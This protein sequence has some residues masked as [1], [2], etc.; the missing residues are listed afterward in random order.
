MRRLLVA[1]FIVMAA[2]VAHAA[3]PADVPILR[4]SYYEAP[5]AAYRTNW[6]G[7]YAGGHF[8]YSSHD[9]DFSRTTVGLQEY[10]LRESALAAIVGQWQLL[11]TSNTR[12]S[13]FGGFVG[14]NAQYEDAIIGIE[15]NYT[16]FAAKWGDS[17]AAITRTLSA[18]DG[19][20]PPPGHSY[21]FDV[22][23]A[24]NARAKVNDMVT[25]RA[26]GG[27]A[28]G[29]FM[30]YVFGG[31]AVALVD[32]D[33]AA[34]VR[35]RTRDL[36]DETVIIG[37]DAG[38][39]PITTIVPRNIVISD[40]TDAKTE[41]QKNLL[42]FGFTAGLGFEYM[43]MQNIFLRAEYEYAQ[44]PLAKDTVIQLNTG[45]IGLGAKF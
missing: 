41:S 9:F 42:T 1:G 2:Q 26:R 19:I 36:F 8:G 12:A 13:G 10:M 22:T 44:L 31:L 14:Y 29:N 15:A 25:L 45:R 38:G 6:G 21:E 28:M 32:I 34:T 27:Y 23:L 4:G 18:V 20:T 11:G 33:R 5:K 37:F 43:L 24:G 40:T 30:P 35:V 7:V 39:N 3:D 17:A 16:H